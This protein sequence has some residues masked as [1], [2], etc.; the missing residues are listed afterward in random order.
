MFTFPTLHPSVCSAMNDLLQT[1]AVAGGPGAQWAGSIEDLDEA[2]AGDAGMTGSSRRGGQRMKELALS[3]NAIDCA[4]L[5]LPSAGRSRAKLRLQVKGQDVC[6]VCDY[7][8]KLTPHFSY[9]KG[10]A[11]MLGFFLGLF[12]CQYLVDFL[13]DSCKGGEM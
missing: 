5:T 12:K 13:E 9:K 4:A 8:E 10:S 2:E 6:F 11:V 1:M 3:T 7:L